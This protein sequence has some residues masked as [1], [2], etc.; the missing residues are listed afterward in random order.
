MFNQGD[1]LGYAP[2]ALDGHSYRTGIEGLICIIHQDLSNCWQSVE[3]EP[4][5]LLIL[6]L[7][8]RTALNFTKVI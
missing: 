7:L 4:C 3:S 1:A 6:V 5:G 8:R 2:G